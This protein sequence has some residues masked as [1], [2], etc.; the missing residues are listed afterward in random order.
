MLKLIA[1]VC[2]GGGIGNNGTIPWKCKADL[3]HFHRTTRGHILVMGRV[4]AESCYLLPD[5]TIITVSSNPKALGD[6]VKRNYTEAKHYALGRARQCD[7]FI[8]GGEGIYY[9][10]IN[11]PDL[12]EM[13]ITSIMDHHSCD[14]YF[15]EIEDDDWETLSVKP[16]G[17]GAFLHHYRRRENEDV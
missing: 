17:V 6:H 1:A 11:D 3:K 7:V 9:T 4:T 16:L 10:A 5:R 14:R 2:T 12:K 13:Y 15:P 8:C